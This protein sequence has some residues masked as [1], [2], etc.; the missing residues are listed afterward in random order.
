MW[1]VG[2]TAWIPVPTLLHSPLWASLPLRFSPCK[3]RVNSRPYLIR[4]LG[5]ENELTN[6][7]YFVSA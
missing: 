2:T 5:E 7:R 1:N 3:H 6:I 4:E